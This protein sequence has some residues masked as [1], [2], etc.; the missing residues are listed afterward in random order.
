[1]ASE[2][3]YKKLSYQRAYRQTRLDIAQWVMDHPETFPE[4]LNYCFQKDD[5]ISYRAT[6]ILEFVCLAD[7]NYLVPHFD[8]FFKHLPTIYKDQAVRPLAKIC[9]KLMVAYYKTKD[10]VIIKAI[11]KKH[12]ETITECCFDWM[13]T[14][15]K[16]ACKVYSML[17]LYFLGTEFDWIHPELKTIIKANIYEGSAA[18]KARGKYTLAQIKKFTSK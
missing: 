8:V 5:E 13:I 3:L 17:A 18:Y 16:V 4:L 12:K 6:W 2:E 7:L 1:M 10:P 9:E 14:D 11:Q 15:Q